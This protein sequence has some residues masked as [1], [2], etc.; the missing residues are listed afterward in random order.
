MRSTRA[1]ALALLLMVVSML[2][3]TAPAAATIGVSDITPT[4]YSLQVY[5][6][7]GHVFVRAVVFDYNSWRSISEVIFN[8]IGP[9]NTTVESVI[10]KQYS[11]NGTL[12]D[13]FTQSAGSHFLPL[14]SEF[15]ASDLTAT[16]SERCNM[17]VL[18]AFTSMAA[19]YLT[20]SVIDIHGKIASSNIAV[21]S[22]YI[23][24]NIAV[25]LPLILSASIVATAA[26]IVLKSWKFSKSS[27]LGKKYEGRAGESEIR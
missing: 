21:E 8:A 10:F 16:V 5:P 15:N 4:F 2:A 20:I 9:G 19:D 14:Y 3:F 26:S 11:P 1:G 24:S 12:S 22:G 17:T 13:S 23:G 25:P 18:F 6:S 27:E 7:N